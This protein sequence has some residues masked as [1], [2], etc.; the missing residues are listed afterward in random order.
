MTESKSTHAP[1]HEQIEARAYEIYVERGS[2]DGNDVGN[3]LEAE[4]ELTQPVV[5]AAETHSKHEAVITDSRIEAPLSG[6]LRSRA[7]VA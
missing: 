1:T 3:W 2:V 7:T 5:E 4:A 6:G